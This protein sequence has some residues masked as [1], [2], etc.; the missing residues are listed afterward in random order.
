[1]EVL[2]DW[3]KPIWGKIF[4]F[5]PTWSK[6]TYFCESPNLLVGNRHLLVGNPV[7]GNIFGLKS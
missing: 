2:L 3:R 7:V 4:A 1:M 6:M 5:V